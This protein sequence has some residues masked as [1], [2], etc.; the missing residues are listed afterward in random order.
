MVNK[1]QQHNYKVQLQT[2]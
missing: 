1:A 2:Q